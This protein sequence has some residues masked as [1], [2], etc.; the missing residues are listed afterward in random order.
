MKIVGFVANGGLRL[1][2]VEGDQVID[3]QEVDK[4]I[5][6]DLGEC[7]RRNNGDLSPLKDAAK[8]APA[9]ARRP[10]K[11][12]AYGLPVATPGKVICL[13]LNYL[14]HVKEG[15]QRDNI[16]KFPT[17]FMRGRSSLVP[18]G[19][20]ILRP[21]ASETLDYE[22]ELIFI[23]GKRAKHL[24]PADAY[25][26]IAGYACGNE[27][28]VRE[29][30]RKTTQWDMGKNFDRTGGFG[31]RVV[32]AG[33]GSPRPEGVGIESPLNGEGMQ[34]GNTGELM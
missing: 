28:S 5:P 13:G 17:I 11:G 10:L 25:S 16:P 4:T 31:P 33:G 1:G 12:L 32:T 26:C 14:E 23:V 34:S 3:L 9:A 19:Q 2:V 15:S 24:T 8:R 7:L 20:P 6:S 27:G 22:A 21:K 30:Q 29:F 18:H